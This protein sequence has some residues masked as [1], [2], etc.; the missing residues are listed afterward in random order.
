MKFEQNI[1]TQFKKAGWIEGQ[2]QKAYYNSL[3]QVKEFPSFLK[4]FLYE[5]GNIV[6]EALPIIEEIKFNKKMKSN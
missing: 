6:V 5:Y 4:E 1:Q 3:S 2:K